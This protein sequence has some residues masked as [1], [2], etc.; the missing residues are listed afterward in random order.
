MND[1]FN[2]ITA[3]LS[4]NARFAL[5]KADFYSK[6]YNQG[7]VQTEHLLLGILSQDTSTGAR[8]LAD[9]G[10]TLEDALKTI[11]TPPA[12][13]REK[14]MVSMVSYGSRRFDAPH[15]L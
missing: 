2:S 8:L 3:S 10:V 15:G 4:E 12:E 13:V 14:E 9:E 7:S 6:Q 5:Q 1:D 11:K